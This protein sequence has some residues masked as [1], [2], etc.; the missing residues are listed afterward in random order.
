LTSE[1]PFWLVKNLTLKLRGL[2]LNLGFY[3]SN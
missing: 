2:S 3:R 1:T